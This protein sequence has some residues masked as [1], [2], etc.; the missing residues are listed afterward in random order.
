MVGQKLRSIPFI[1]FFF[2]TAVDYRGLGL[3][4]NFIERTDVKDRGRRKKNQYGK[5]QEVVLSGLIRFYIQQRYMW[6]LLHKAET[7]SHTHA[8]LH[9]DSWS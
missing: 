2:Q 6:Y 1:V 7:L 9:I 5:Y 4:V 3:V 8:H